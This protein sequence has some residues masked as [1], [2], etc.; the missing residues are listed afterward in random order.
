LPIYIMKSNSLKK[1]ENNNIS[2]K[3]SLFDHVKHIR[4]VQDPNYYNNLSEDDRKSFNHFMIVRALAMDDYLVED[5]AQLY[6]VFDKIPSPQFYQLLIALVPRNN[7]FCPW[8]KTR[9]LKHNK[10]LLSYVAKRFNVSKYQAN[11][12]VNLLLRTENGQSE[13]VA[14]CKAFGLENKE[15]E[16][17]FEAPKYE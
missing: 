3:K 4:S 12:Y 10:L 11:D 15:V 8:I 16:E 2:K 17:L 7:N 6:Q 1:T 5:M 9:T 14:I 13:L